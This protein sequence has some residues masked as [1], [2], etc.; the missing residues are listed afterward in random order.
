MS[1][2][3]MAEAMSTALAQ[4]RS[5]ADPQAV[6]AA[7]TAQMAG[8]MR[9]L[10]LG[11]IVLGVANVAMISAA[12]VR[13]LHDSNRSGL[14]AALAGAIYLAVL[15]MSWANAGAVS[16]AMRDLAAASTQVETLGIQARL[17]RQSL[18]GYVPIA[19]VIVIGLLK[20]SPGPNR[21][22]EAPV[23]F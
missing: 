21:F 16:A 8:A 18:L 15:W 7:V 19:M 13:R 1:V 9:P 22:G 4:T 2:P 23:S 20:S 3:M 6:Q 11:G 5:G 17:A 14:W 12:L 10:V